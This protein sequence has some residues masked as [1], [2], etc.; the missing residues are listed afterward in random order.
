[1]IGSEAT[2]DEILSF[3]DLVSIQIQFKNFKCRHFF[4]KPFNSPFNSISFHSYNVNAVL[5]FINNFVFM[6]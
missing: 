1:M 3:L 2:D 5:P 6:L 4:E